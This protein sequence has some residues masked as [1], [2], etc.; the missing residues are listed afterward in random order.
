MATLDDL[1][2]QEQQLQ[3]QLAQLAA[4]KEAAKQRDHDE[5][6]G[7][8]TVYENEATGYRNQAEKATADDEKQRLYRFAELADEQAND[9][10]RELGLVSEQQQQATTEERQQAAKLNVSRKINSL[11]LKS[12]FAFVSFLIADFTSARLELGFISFG[13]KSIAQVSYFLS[14]AF[15]GCWLA[16]TILAGFVSQYVF[17]GLRTDFKSLSPTAR[18]ALLVAL[19]AAILHFFTAIPTDAI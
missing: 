11:L 15:G 19:F 2:T 5:K 16:C 3:A 9:L 1:T 17:T 18:L 4:D 12:L 8:I 7:L 14:V 13:L 10:R 6:L